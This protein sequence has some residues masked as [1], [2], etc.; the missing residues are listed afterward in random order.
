MGAFFMPPLMISSG[1]HMGVDL[2][3]VAGMVFKTNVA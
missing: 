1:I 2:V 3:L